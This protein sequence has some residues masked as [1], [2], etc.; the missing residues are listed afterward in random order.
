MG[1]FSLFATSTERSFHEV[2]TPR[3]SV[4]DVSHVLD[5]LLHPRPCGF[6]SPRCHVQGSPFRGFPSRAAALPHRQ[7]CPLAVADRSLPEVA[8]Q[9]HQLPARPQ[10]LVPREN[11]SSRSTG[12]SRRPDPIPSWA[13]PPP[14]VSPR[15]RR[16]GSPFAPLSILSVQASQSPAPMTLS[17]SLFEARPISPETDRPARGS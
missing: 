5:G 4:R 17:V 9:R 3:G 15:T 1:S 11:P 6:V 2:P 13:S 12:F 7:P 8:P 16:T 14:G 10:G